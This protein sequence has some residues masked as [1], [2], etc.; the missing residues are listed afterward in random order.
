MCLLSPATG[1]YRG[2]GRMFTETGKQ[3]NNLR[4]EKIATR[5]PRQA[6]AAAPAPAPAANNNATRPRHEIFLRFPG[7][8]GAFSVSILID[9]IQT[10]GQTRKIVFTSKT[11]PTSAQYPPTSVLL[12]THQKRAQNR[13]KKSNH[14]LHAGISVLYACRYLK[15]NNEKRS[16]LTIPGHRTS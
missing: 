13:R 2:E 9:L 12:R 4:T 6:A 16:T 14:H 8:S 5:A 7:R 15:R 3:E 11:V 1:M 10:N